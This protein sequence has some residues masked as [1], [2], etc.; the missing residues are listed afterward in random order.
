MMGRSAHSEGDNEGIAALSA[1][2]A[3][4]RCGMDNEGA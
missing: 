4:T 1:L 3:S 2:Y